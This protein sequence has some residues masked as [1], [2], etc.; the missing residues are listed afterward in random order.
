MSSHRL[1]RLALAL[2]QHRPVRRYAFR[3]MR[4][5]AVAM[6]LRDHPQ[7][8]PE[9]LMIERAQRKGDPWSGHMAFPGGLG[10]SHDFSPLHTALRETREET[11]IDTGLLRSLGH[12]SELRTH[13]SRSGDRGPLCVRPY[14]FSVNLPLSIRLNHEAVDSIWLPLDFVA[15]PA[16]RKTMHWLWKGRDMALPC[17]FFQ[18]K[19][20]WGLSLQML[21]ELA[22]L[23]RR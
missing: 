8:G 3:A 16:N 11:G 1:S 20:I 15:D 12:L 17:Y 9:V 19:R 4:S 18:G 2:A 7:Q 21:D 22:G 5:A 13:A 23:D 10:E 6:I 14:V